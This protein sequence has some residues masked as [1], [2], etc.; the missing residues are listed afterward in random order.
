MQMK[1]LSEPR[2]QSGS[3]GVSAVKVLVRAVSIAE[4][5][6]AMHFSA[7]FRSRAT[8]RQQVWSRLN[9]RTS[10]GAGCAILAIS[11]VF[12]AGRQTAHRIAFSI[13]AA[14]PQATAALASAP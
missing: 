4:T 2:V 9:K 12:K 7:A 11:S 8:Y 6:G 5:A 10:H 13:H 1:Q 14:A 3:S